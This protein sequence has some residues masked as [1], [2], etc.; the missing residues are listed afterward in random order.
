MRILAYEVLTQLIIWLGKLRTKVAAGVV[1]QRKHDRT[2]YASNCEAAECCDCGLVHI[3]YPLH[4]E[5]MREK[6]FRLVPQRPRDYR[7]KLRIACDPPS[8]FVDESR[9]DP[10]TGIPRP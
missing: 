8:A 5:E 9:L 7:Y 6:H 2:F 10:W 4:G 3:H 1:M